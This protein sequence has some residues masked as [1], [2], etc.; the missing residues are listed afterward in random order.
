[1]VAHEKLK[2]FCQSQPQVSALLVVCDTNDTRLNRNQLFGKLKPDFLFFFYLNKSIKRAA[3]SS[4]WEAT[5][6][7]RKEGRKEVDKKS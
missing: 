1:M 2:V 3:I 5:T 6:D 4:F 7:T